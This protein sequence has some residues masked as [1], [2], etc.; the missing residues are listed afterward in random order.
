[1][2]PE[3][4]DAASVQ[5]TDEQAFEDLEDE[6]PFEDLEA[7]GAQDEEAEGEDSDG[8]QPMTP[9]PQDAHHHTGAAKKL[10]AGAEL[11]QIKDAADLYQSSSFKLQVRCAIISTWT[12]LTRSQ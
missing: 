9:P 4:E 1:M 7:D 12:Q 2:S 6:A 5:S 3:E 10:P 8:D 11:R